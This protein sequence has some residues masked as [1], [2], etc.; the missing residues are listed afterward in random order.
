M[1]A[2]N[3]LEES[4]VLRVLDGIKRKLGPL[5]QSARLF[6][7]QSDFSWSERHPPT[8]IVGDNHEAFQVAKSIRD[9]VLL[10]VKELSY[11]ESL[12]LVVGPIARIEEPDEEPFTA[13]LIT[14]MSP[15]TRT[16]VLAV[17]AERL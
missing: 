6:Q 8:K 15:D 1:I 9:R 12:S 16:M 11:P 3:P 10:V 13:V 17:Y 14:A 5:G 4:A 2:K 7:D